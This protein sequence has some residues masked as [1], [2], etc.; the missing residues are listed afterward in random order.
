MVT[1]DHTWQWIAMLLPP[2]R[3]LFDLFSVIF[4]E[5]LCLVEF[6]ID[7]AP[8]IAVHRVPLAAERIGKAEVHHHVTRPFQREGEAIYHIAP[9]IPTILVD[10]AFSTNPFTKQEAFTP[11]ACQSFE[12]AKDVLAAF[13]CPI[14]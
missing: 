7:I 5:S 9:P 6:T 8:A 1:D 10:T 12:N 4:Y 2:T 3:V 13:F 11:H 14:L